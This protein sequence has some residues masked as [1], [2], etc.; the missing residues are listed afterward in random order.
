[1]ARHGYLGAT[2]P[3]EG[4]HGYF[5]LYANGADGA[6]RSLDGLGSD[7]EVMNTAVKPYPCCR[8]SHA[9]IDA[10]SDI[11]RAESLASSDIEG[12]D[13]ATGRDRLWPRRG[14]RRRQASPLQRRRGPVQRLL[15]R[16]SHRQPGR[17]RLGRLRPSHRPRGRPPHARFLRPA[18]GRRGRGHGDLRDCPRLR[19][20]RHRTLRFRTPR[21]SRRTRCRGRK[22]RRS[23][24][25][26]ARTSSAK[27]APGK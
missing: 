26:G 23:S 22:C 3:I 9:T 2:S 13:I 11:V 10:V 21:A 25:N 14:S 19:R 6:E 12:I 17:L 24:P 8:Y 27:S 16:R 5:A 1:M 20:A 15:R 4:G 18:R 7:F